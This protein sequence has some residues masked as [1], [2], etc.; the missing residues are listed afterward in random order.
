[1]RSLTTEMADLEPEIRAAVT[2][3]ATEEAAALGEFGNGDGQP[4]EIRSLMLN[5]GLADY[6]NPAASNGGRLEGRAVELNKA[7]GADVVG[8][9]GGIIV[10]FA[11]LEQR[12]FTT[13]TQN[14]GSLVQRPILQRLFGASVLETLG[15]RLDSVPSGRSEWPLIAT[16]VAPDQAKEGT[17]AAAAVAATFTT[18]VHKPKRLTGR[19]EI[20]HEA[21]ASVGDLESALRADLADSVMSKMSDRVINGTAPTNSNPQ[22]IEGF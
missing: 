2:V 4:A 3:A 19:Y 17:A 16:G 20:S 13:T 22:Y 12:A 10:P 6:M 1:M 15:V 9:G 8:K 5:V 14:D 21:L 7:L 11:M 18:A